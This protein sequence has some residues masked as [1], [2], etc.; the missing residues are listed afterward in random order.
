MKTVAEALRDNDVE[1]EFASVTESLTNLQE[2]MAEKRDA[3]QAK[4]RDVPKHKSEMILKLSSLKKGLNEV[5]EAFENTLDEREE[6]VLET[7]N[8]NMQ[9]Y[10]S[11][12]EQIRTSLSKFHDM[13]NTENNPETL[14][15][16][17][18]EL[19][20]IYKNLKEQLMEIEDL[21]DSDTFVVQDERLPMMIESLKEISKSDELFE[22]SLHEDLGKSKE[23]KHCQT[24]PASHDTID[25]CEEGSAAGETMTSAEGEH[26]KGQ[27]DETDHGSSELELEQGFNNIGTKSFLSIKSC[28]NLR[29]VTVSSLPSKV[30]MLQDVRIIYQYGYR[31]EILDKDMTNIATLKLPRGKSDG[32]FKIYDVIDVTSFDSAVFDSKR[33]AILVSGQRTLLSGENENFDCFQLATLIPAIE[34]GHDIYLRYRCRKIACHNNKIYVYTPDLCKSFIECPG[35]VIM[36]SNGDVLHT[37]QFLQDLTC[38]CPDKNG[39]IV[40]FGS[41][42]REEKHFI[43]CVSK[44]GKEL[45][46]HS[47][48]VQPTSM[49]PDT[50][51][52]LL[53]LHSSGNI[54]VLKSNGSQAQCLLTPEHIDKKW[55]ATFMCYNDVSNTIL[56]GGYMY[57]SDD[58]VPTHKLYLF[59]LQY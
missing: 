52:N 47:C 33:V 58:Y 6:T 56:I 45:Y 55:R 20:Q 41:R 9:S 22:L 40:F 8:A 48:S 32:Q 31:L 42:N 53:V 51:G 7:A 46:K 5:L 44:E 12:S 39:D 11:F 35:V 27:L 2:Q 16:S 10:S 3:N 24:D 59:Q 13:E 1:A 18:V 21:S 23:D 49:V 19:K 30:C 29:N 15:Y 50:E 4:L 54:T 38:F 25:F 14:F 57:I 37:V 28:Q 17:V 36:A 34:L 26:S 43:K